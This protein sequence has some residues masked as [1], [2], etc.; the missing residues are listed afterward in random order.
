MF[1]IACGNDD[2]TFDDRWQIENEAQF[3]YITTHP[4]FIR[5]ESLSGNGHIMYRVLREGDQS[6]R[7]PFFNEQVW[8]NYRGWFKNDWSM[9]ATFVNDR[10]HRI[11]NKIVFDRTIDDRENARPRLF[12]PS[13]LIPGFADALQ[14]MRPGDKWEVWIPWNLGYGRRPHANI[15]AYTTLVFEIEI[16]EERLNN[17]L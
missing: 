2:E 17:H 5:L 10:G 14:R 8:V 1:F 9:P 6:R 15:R 13:Q 4:D 7:S 12:T 11:T 3:A 16:V